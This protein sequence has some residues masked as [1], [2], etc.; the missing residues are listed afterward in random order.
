MAAGAQAARL[1]LFP[2]A[3]LA[4]IHWKGRSR[5]SGDG[6]ASRIWGAPSGAVKRRAALP[7]A[8]A[9]ARMALGASACSARAAILATAPSLSDS[10][11]RRGAGEAARRSEGWCQRAARAAVQAAGAARELWVL[12]QR[13]QGAQHVQDHSEG[14]LGGSRSALQ[15][16]KHTLQDPQPLDSPS[17]QAS[18]QRAAHLTG[19][20]KQSLC[21]SPH[22]LAHTAASHTA[23]HSQAGSARILTC[24]FAEMLSSNR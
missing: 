18:Q 8:C 6:R 15:R 1:H 3:R 23:L 13:G 10:M 17:S 20:H 16:A 14:S 24:G 2:H 12:L 19:R 9:P 22:R 11:A 21:C 5:S 4:C 7:G